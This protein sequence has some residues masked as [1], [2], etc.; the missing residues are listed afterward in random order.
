[1]AMDKDILGKAIADR[2]MPSGTTEELMTTVVGIWT[3]VADEVIKHIEE[4][5]GFVGLSATMEFDVRVNRVGVG[6][7]TFRGTIG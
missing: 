3:K 4:N 7:A 5:S 1:M 2:L 6:T